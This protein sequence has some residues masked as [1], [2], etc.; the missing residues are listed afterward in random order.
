MFGLFIGLAVAGVVST[1]V[2]TVAS[3]SAAQGAISEQSQM[4]KQ[5]ELE[6]SYKDLSEKNQTLD[7]MR[8]ALQTN[9]AHMS[10]TGMAANS[11]SFVAMNAQTIEDGDRAIRNSDVAQ[12]LNDYSL[13][14]KQQAAQRQAYAQEIGSLADMG[15]S[16]ASL[17]GNLSYYSGSEYK[18]SSN[19]SHF[20]TTGTTSSYID[21]MFHNQ[22][23]RAF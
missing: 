3:I 13:K 11:G 9:E 6:N 23:T 5:Q 12:A 7:Q 16:L 17:G 4:M 19:S 14:I 18:P 20:S 8:D 2:S 10:A 21:N 22:I 15:S 1:V